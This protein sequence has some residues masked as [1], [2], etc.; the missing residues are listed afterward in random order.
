[1]STANRFMRATMKTIKAGMQTI[2]ATGAV[3]DGHVTWHLLPPP[4]GVC[5]KCAHD[6][7]PEQPHNFQT[8]YY[9]YAFYADHDRWPTW[10]DALAHC[11]PEMKA[12]WE[13]EL[14]ARGA[15]ND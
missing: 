13:K 15:W 11:S 10:A 2:D 1:M 4:A 5:Q 9:K 3:K 8:L 12:A 7:S 14:R 6:H